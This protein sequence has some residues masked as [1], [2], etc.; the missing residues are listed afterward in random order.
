[1]FASRALHHPDHR[2]CELDLAAAGCDLADPASPPSILQPPAEH[3]HS[4]PTDTD[5]TI[6][7]KAT[8][9]IPRSARQL[10]IE[11]EEEAARQVQ[12]QRADFCLL[13]FAAVGRNFIKSLQMQIEVQNTAGHLISPARASS[14]HLCLP[15]AW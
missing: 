2:Q 11:G 13:Y 5:R 14:A 8:T 3:L 10:S 12:M 15:L 6:P 1:M 7:S 9:L 4:A